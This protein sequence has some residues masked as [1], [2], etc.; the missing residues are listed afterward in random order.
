MGILYNGTLYECD[1]PA[2]NSYAVDSPQPGATSKVPNSWIVL[3]TNRTVKVAC[4]LQCARVVLNNIW[5]GPG[6]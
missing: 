2:C 4:S 3:E 5:I 1:H 6:V